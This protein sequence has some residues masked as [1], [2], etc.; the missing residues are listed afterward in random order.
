MNH[1]DQQLRDKCITDGTFNKFLDRLSQLTGEKKRV[2]VPEGGVV[3]MPQQITVSTTKAEPVKKD[4]KGE[5]KGVGYTTGTGSIWNVQE[6]LD[7]K[8]SKNSQI[9]NIISILMHSIKG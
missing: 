9:L 7:S 6:Y 3:T 4:A 2:K 5:K 8:D 1:I